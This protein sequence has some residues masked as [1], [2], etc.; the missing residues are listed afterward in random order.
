MTHNKEILRKR[1]F[2][3]LLLLFLLCGCCRTASNNHFGAYPVIT[4]IHVHYQ[5]QTLEA[6]RTFS[7]PE[8]IQRITNYLRRIDPYG[9]P[10]QDPEQLSGSNFR[11]TLFYSNGM[12]RLYHQR[13]DQYL[14]VDDGPWERID[15]VKAM[16]LSHLLGSLESDTAAADFPSAPL[17]P[18]I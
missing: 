17:H 12:Q 4:E 1:N 9:T 8:K 14:K 10:Q 15:P 13:S 6:F 11:I 3:I 7:Q 2:F 16:E 18:K 5:N